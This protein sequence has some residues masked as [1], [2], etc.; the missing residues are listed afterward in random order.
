MCV[1]V[2]SDTHTSLSLSHYQLA[3]HPVSH[4]SVQMVRKAASILSSLSLSRLRHSLLEK[5]KKVMPAIDQ[6]QI[7]VGCMD[8]MSGEFNGKRK[9]NCDQL[10]VSALSLSIFHL[11]D[12]LKQLFT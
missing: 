6:C 4:P 9:L 7:G 3:F 8:W 11:V 12:V 10:K 1:G 5:K 2:Y